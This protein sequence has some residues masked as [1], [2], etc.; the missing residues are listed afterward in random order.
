MRIL[1]VCLGN[2][3]RSPYAASVLAHHGGVTMSVRSA[4]LRGKWAGGPAHARML[5]VA[6]ARG[7]DL[8]GHR[9]VQVSSALL[10]WAD[11][12]L[13]M[14]RVVLGE[15][16]GRTGPNIGQLAL[17]LGNRDVPDPYGGD[18]NAFTA[19]A[20]LI[21]EAAPQHLP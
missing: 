2:I 19:C 12:V 4:G 20:D 13:A 17:Y 3:C 6:T 10:E 8:T 16:R 9:A 5:H 21:E 7:Y 1:T 14:D 15:L 11:L 18:E